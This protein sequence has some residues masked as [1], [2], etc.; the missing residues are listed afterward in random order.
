MKAVK[1]YFKSTFD[2]NS[3]SFKVKD[4]RLKSY[5]LKFKPSREGS[6]IWEYEIVNWRV[7]KKNIPMV[8]SPE[9]RIVDESKREWHELQ[10]GRFVQ[11]RC[12]AY[13]YFASEE[14]ANTQ[15]VWALKGVRIPKYSKN[16]KIITEVDLEDY[17][18]SQTL[19]INAV[20][21]S[22][23]GRYTCTFT[24]SREKVKSTYKTLNYEGS[25]P[26]AFL[27]QM[28]LESD[29]IFFSAKR[30][31]SATGNSDPANLV[32]SADKLCAITGQTTNIMK[33]ILRKPFTH[34]KFCCQLSKITGDKGLLKS[35][36][37]LKT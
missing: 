21:F 36:Y 26:G 1:F 7:F 2:G 19:V 18:M 6:F 4:N 16:R 11:F 12:D 22:D 10:L 25:D 3:K 14:N 24:E 32:L 13:S 37:T 23:I 28:F 15:L 29:Q 30:I 33:I 27:P 8:F 17:I 5:F 31:W 20:Q 9:V 35:S 34:T